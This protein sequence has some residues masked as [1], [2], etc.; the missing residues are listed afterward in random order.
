MT[1]V[2]Q[3][4][5]IAGHEGAY[6]VSDHGR[7]RS[8]DRTIGGQ[9]P[10]STRR[11]KG[12]VLT[13]VLAE[14]Y[15]K[16]SLSKDGEVRQHHVAVLVLEAFVGPRPPSLEACHWDGNPEN[17]YR[18]NLRWDTGSA[19]ALDR[20]RHGRNHLVGRGERATHCRYRH[21]LVERNLVKSV[22]TNEGRKKCLAC[23]RATNQKNKAKAAGKLFDFRATADRIY[24][25]IMMI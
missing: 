7:V 23:R 19:N 2:E 1:S 25:E 12:R 4:R 3:W 21:Q 6:E 11:W 9:K 16:V 14:G 13:L 22:L 15:Q 20:I 24:A 5:S 18:P 17:N 10:G 8:L